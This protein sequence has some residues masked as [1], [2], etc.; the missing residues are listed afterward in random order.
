MPRGARRLLDAAPSAKALAESADG[1]SRPSEQPRHRSRAASSQGPKWEEPQIGA[2]KLVDPKW[3]EARLGG[4]P[5]SEAGTRR[6][7]GRRRCSAEEER[8]PRGGAH[9]G[10]LPMLCVGLSQ[11]ILSRAWPRQR[12]HHGL[13]TVSLDV[14]GVAIV[15]SLTRFAQDNRDEA[16]IQ[17]G[18]RDRLSVGRYNPAQPQP[19]P[20]SR[21]NC[22][23]S[24]LAIRSFGRAASIVRPTICCRFRIE[25]AAEVVAQIDGNPANRGKAQRGGGESTRPLMTSY[26]G[27]FR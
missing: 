27:R 25:I 16:A 23:T 6:R 26:C 24:G 8:L 5:A 14:R 21:S 18:V 19:A 10:V 4:S 17:R 3:G 15:S 20:A 11:E 1:N 13:V 9:V 2:S 12:N 7:P 22:S